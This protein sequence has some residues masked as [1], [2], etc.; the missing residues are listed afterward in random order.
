M[1]AARLALAALLLLLTALPVHEAG[2]CAFAWARGATAA[3]VIIIAY[4]GETVGPVA[5]YEAWGEL[6]CQ[7]HPG[8]QHRASARP[9][10][11]ADHAA[12]YAAHA[13]LA[14]AALWTAWREPRRRA[15]ASFTLQA[16]TASRE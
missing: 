11:N 8:S 15:R 4:P 6:T 10:S 2:H 12:L 1:R 13:G 9:G 3:C 16:R 5:C 7:E 14:L